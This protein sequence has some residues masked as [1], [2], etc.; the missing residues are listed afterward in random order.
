MLRAI[1]QNR[2]RCAWLRRALI[3]IAF[4]LVSAARQASAQTPPPRIGPFTFDIHG[5]VPK[6][7]DDPQLALSRGLNTT[8]LP[9]A[10][11]GASAGLHFYLPKIAGITIGLGAEAIVARSSAS[12]DTGSSTTALAVTETFKEVSPQLSLNFGSGKGWSYLSAGIGRSMWSVVA[13]NAPASPADEEI[14]STINY[15]GGARWFAKN[16]LAFSLDVRL[17]E[18]ENGTPTPGRPGSP[19]TVLLVIGAGISLK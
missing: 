15:G 8:D 13:E 4:A 19:R 7:G 2:T 16:H 5:V 6:F 14:L 12:S 18:I 17:Y 1:H 3:A 11:F 10:G 9:G